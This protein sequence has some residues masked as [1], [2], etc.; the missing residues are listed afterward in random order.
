MERELAAIEFRCPS[1][2][3]PGKL[4]RVKFYQ[5]FV[6]KACQRP[7]YLNEA[8]RA[9]AGD[10][11]ASFVEPERPRDV[12]ESR[13]PSV[14]D[15]QEMTQR[16]HGELREKLEA[17][18]ARKVAY[19]LG[20]FVVVALVLY[21]VLS[22]GE[23]LDRAAA[24]AAEALRRDDVDGLKAIAAAGTAADVGRWYD[25]VHPRLVQA[26]Q[27]WNGKPETAEVHVAQEDR[28]A[29]KGSAGLSL[30]PIQSTSGLDVSLA[31]PAEMTASA[32][33]P[34]EV[35]TAW[36]RGAWGGWKLDG[37]ETYAR[38]HPPGP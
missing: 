36:T 22:P 12:L 1:C 4:S 19:G 25:E 11:P 27:G 17:F 23:R 37:R 32:P 18:P 2:K 6:C 15:L 5:R 38:A 10:P 14:D 33:S 29:R 8:G 20:A 34:V 35:E 7:F 13:M 26:R 30:H 28:A 24:R 31:N 21:L 16:L 3:R 9:L